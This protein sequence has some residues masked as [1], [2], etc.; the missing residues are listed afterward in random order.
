VTRA[1][2]Q[3]TSTHRKLTTHWISVSLT[4]HGGK[5]YSSRGVD[6]RLGTVTLCT[7]MRSGGPYPRSPKTN[8]RI[9]R[10]GDRTYHLSIPSRMACKS[11]TEILNASASPSTETALRRNPSAALRRRSSVTAAMV[12]FP[13]SR[14]TKCSVKVSE[15]GGPCGSIFRL[16]LSEGQCCTSTGPT[17]TLNSRS[18]TTPFSQS[19][20]VLPRANGLDA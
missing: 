11:V 20:C 12:G 5:E 19:I 9:V 14:E 16:S 13:V 6:C 3:S 2:V 18:I 1:W 4:C 17:V 7:I 15:P 10:K 8:I